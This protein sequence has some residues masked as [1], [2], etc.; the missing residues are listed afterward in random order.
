[1]STT[2]IEQFEPQSLDQFYERLSGVVKPGHVRR[3]GGKLKL[4]VPMEQVTGFRVAETGPVMRCKVGGREVEVLLNKFDVKIQM[5]DKVTVELGERRV[6]KADALRKA[7]EERAM[8]AVREDLWK[9]GPKALAQ[10]VAAPTDLAAVL[11]ALGQASG[12][13][14]VEMDPVAEAKL[15]GVE[16]R[17]RLLEAHGGVLSA[18]DAAKALGMTRQGIDKRRKEGRLLAVESGRRG[19]QYPAWQFTEKGTMEG[20]EG[21]L[22]ALKHWDPWTQ[23]GFFVTENTSLGE[24]TPLEALRA[25]QAKAVKRAAA[26]YGEQGAA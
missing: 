23:A 13:A 10:A 8:R 6:E 26:I 5:G 22:G 25:G 19:W 1:M 3:K 7:F 4:T 11:V 24:K 2:K 16:A 18:A 12:S 21:V 15:R 17:R 9:L 20:L 14:L